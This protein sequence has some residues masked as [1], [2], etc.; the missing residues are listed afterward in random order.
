[1]V[2]AIHDSLHSSYYST[3]L[4]RTALAVDLQ[5]TITLDYK[6]GSLYSVS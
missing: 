1:M 2:Y 6:L 4:I 3:D 5:T